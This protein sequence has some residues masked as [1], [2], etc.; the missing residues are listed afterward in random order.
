M[1]YQNFSGQRSIIYE[2]CRQFD[3]RIIDEN[4]QQNRKCYSSRSTDII[5]QDE[6]RDCKSLFTITPRIRD[7]GKRLL[8]QT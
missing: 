7:L 6:S 8:V 1:F 4:P 5:G 2:N 3:C